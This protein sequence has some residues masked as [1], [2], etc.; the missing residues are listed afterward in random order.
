MLKLVGKLFL[1][2]LFCGVPEFILAKGFLNVSGWCK[3][4]G[5]WTLEID[6]ARLHKLPLW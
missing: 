2:I 5:T 3:L 4:N 6:K 1:K